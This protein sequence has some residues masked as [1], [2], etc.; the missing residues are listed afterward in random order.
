MAQEFSPRIRVKT[1]PCIECIYPS[2]PRVSFTVCSLY[3]RVG[4]R[5]F[6]AALFSA[7][8]RIFVFYTPLNAENPPSTG[9]TVPVTKADAGLINHNNVP[10]KSSGLPN[11]PIG[12]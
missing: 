8:S 2:V 4:N 6:Y 11:R 3:S 10:I 1:H 9:I 5:L 12:V 7:E